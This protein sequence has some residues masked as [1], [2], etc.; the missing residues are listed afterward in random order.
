MNLAIIPARSG[1]KRIK[2]KNIKT[3]FSKPIISYSILAAKKSKLFKHV[4][5]ST[6]SHSI[7][8]ISKKIGA[9][10]FFLRPKN[11]SK[12][13]STTQQVINHSIQWFR[14]KNINFKYICCI[15]PVAPL[16]TPEHLKKSFKKIKKEKW[17]FILSAIEYS[18]PIHRA[19]YLKKKRVHF[20]KQNFFN[21]KSNK[22]KKNFYDAG[23]FYWGTS[24]AWGKKNIIKNCN[25]TIYQIPKHLAEDINS[26][27]DW[28][29]LKKLYKVLKIKK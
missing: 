14:K 2:N 25:S 17:D 7:A 27:E 16:L 13:S 8:K 15:Y 11:I 24:S 3:F 23:Q 5:V 1:S 19:L 6:D 29:Y 28:D 12:D 21:K 20:E 4:I 9:S 22:K 26:K 18:S 10:V